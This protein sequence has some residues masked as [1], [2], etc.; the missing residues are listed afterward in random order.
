MNVSW[1]SVS[2]IRKQLI[3]ILLGLVV[4]VSASAKEGFFPNQSLPVNV[5]Q[6]GNA[7]G[8]L[9]VEQQPNAHYGLGTATWICTDDRSSLLLTANHTVSAQ[10]CEDNCDLF[11]DQQGGQVISRSF[12][13]QGDIPTDA[14]QSFRISAQDLALDLV[15]LEPTEFFQAPHC[16]DPSKFKDATPEDEAFILGFP[17]L[18]HRPSPVTFSDIIAKR[19]SAGRVTS[20]RHNRF[21]HSFVSDA[22]ALPGSSG[23]L[24]FAPSGD[25]LGLVHLIYMPDT[26]PGAGPQGFE[27]V[28][29]GGITLFVPGLKVRSFLQSALQ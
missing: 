8:F 11:W 18:V 10:H 1:Q 27:I 13:L 25:V 20:M 21:P 17:Y 15:L 4:G 26:I 14:K 9:M 5:Q 24:V 3:I 23:S 19:G 16:L 22:D 29:Y 6:Q 12:Q 28:P 2:H 7:V